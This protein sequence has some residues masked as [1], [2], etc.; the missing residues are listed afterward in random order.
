M[1]PLE[2]NRQKV[3]EGYSHL[4]NR[5]LGLLQVAYNSL[6]LSYSDG[7]EN[8]W[9]KAEKVAFWLQ[10]NPLEILILDKPTEM[11]PEK[12]KELIKN[13][14][15]LFGQ[16]Y[17]KF[18]EFT[19]TV[20]SDEGK[21]LKVDPVIFT[22]RLLADLDIPKNHF[23]SYRQIIESKGESVLRNNLPYVS[24]EGRFDPNLP[25]NKYYEKVS[26]KTVNGILDSF[27]ELV[28]LDLPSYD[29]EY[30][31]RVSL[32]AGIAALEVLF[33]DE[34]NQRCRDLLK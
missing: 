20:T 21:A 32:L 24:I 1:I 15:S 33:L 26:K 18:L 9:G 23:D 27:R 4:A 11:L 14:S 3:M 22:P 2:N 17:P 19:N 16:N 5:N 12:R 8:R 31:E 7:V 28:D 30:K 29:K 10:T 13:P 34:N 25:K 6:Y